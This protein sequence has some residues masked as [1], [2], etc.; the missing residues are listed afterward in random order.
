MTKSWMI[1]LLAASVPAAARP[2]SVIVQGETRPT[3]AV[4]VAGLDLTREQDVDRL[5]QRVDR[6]ARSVCKP[7]V[8]EIPA[9]K[10]EARA[11]FEETRANAYSEIQRVRSALRQ[12]R[13]TDLAAIAVGAQRRR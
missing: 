6:A 13:K 2:G 5:R 10:A 3:I 8:I 12:G 4:P 9:V 7:Q 1:L 11:C